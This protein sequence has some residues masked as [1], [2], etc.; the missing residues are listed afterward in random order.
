MDS[1]IVALLH[2]DSREVVER[3]VGLGGTGLIIQRGEYAFKIPKLCRDVE[4]IDGERTIGRLT[5]QPGEYDERKIMIQIIEEEKAIYRRL[6]ECPGIIQCYDLESPDHSIQMKL[7]KNG[8]LRHYLVATRPDRPTQL[9][10]LM[11]L[12]RTLVHIHNRR[13]VVCDVR[14]DNILLDDDFTVKMTDFGE[15]VMMPLD[16]NME[17]IVDLGWSVSTDIGAFGA[18]MFE[19]VTGQH[20]R[21]DL[22]QD[23]KEAGD[24]FTW[25]RRDSLPATDGVWLGHIIEY[26]W[27][28]GSFTSAEELVARL[29]QEK[30]KKDEAA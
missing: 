12:A 20:C 13:V 23:W 27:T 5:P 6:G 3:V 30:V 16:W 22:M 29:E 24:P 28:E 14:T 7:M 1:V 10:W 9:S 18:V 17:G 21:F 25:P 26:C 15:S 19:I 2:T 8:D 4:M 11:D